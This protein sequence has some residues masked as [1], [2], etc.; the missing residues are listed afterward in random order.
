[1]TAIELASPI[2]ATI[3]VLRA[4]AVVG[5]AGIEHIHGGEIPKDRVSI[6][7]PRIVVVP[8]GLPNPKRDTLPTIIRR[9]DA[10]CYGRT[11]MEAE[12][13]QLAVVYAL[14][15]WK[16]GV[17]ERHLVHWLNHVSGPVTM[18]D[19]NTDQPLQVVTFN[20]QMVRERVPAV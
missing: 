13:V 7:E 17:A 6:D 2:T 11:P 4:S 3:A 8:S 20:I 5:E 16:Y 1:M 12:Q 14:T 15:V 9:V 10:R 19:P 18:R